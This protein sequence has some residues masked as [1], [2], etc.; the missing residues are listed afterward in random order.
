M[1]PKLIFLIYRPFVN[2]DCLVDE[3]ATQNQS[4]GIKGFLLTRIIDYATHNYDLVIY[5]QW[6]TENSSGTSLNSNYPVYSRHV[7]WAVTRESR[8]FKYFGSSLKKMADLNGV[9]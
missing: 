8:H 3:S 6:F 7:P 1:P 5:A 4:Y 2:L 9:M